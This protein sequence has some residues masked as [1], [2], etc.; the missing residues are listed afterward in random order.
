MSVWTCDVNKQI[1]ENLEFSVRPFPVGAGAKVEISFKTGMSVSGSDQE[2]VW[3]DA[4]NSDKDKSK[5]KK[6]NARLTKAP[7]T[8]EVCPPPSAFMPPSRG[9]TAAIH[10]TPALLF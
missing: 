10:R 6:R 5:D 7:W 4:S 8:K 3:M 2:N 9:L 1:R